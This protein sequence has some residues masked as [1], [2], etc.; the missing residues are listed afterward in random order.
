MLREEGLAVGDRQGVGIAAQGRVLDPGE[1]RIAG[2][3]SVARGAEVA[4][5]GG[6]GGLILS[7]ASR[8]LL[9]SLLDDPWEQHNATIPFDGRVFAF[10]LLVTFA[11][12]TLFGLLPAWLA[13]RK[14]VSSQLKES[15]HQATRRRKSWSGKAVVALQIALSTVLVI[16]AGIFLHTVLSLNSIDLGFDP[17][18]ILMFDISPPG[19]KYTDNKAVQLHQQLE[20]QIAAL[21]GVE[22]VSPAWIP[23]AGGGMTNSGFLTEDKSTNS[24]DN[25]P[26]FDNVVGNDYFRTMRIPIVAGRAF[27]AS[28]TPSSLKVAVINQALA[29][30]RFPN[31][32]PIGKRFK[33]GDGPKGDEAGPDWYQIVGICADTRYAQVK[34][35]PPPVFYLPYVQQKDSSD[36]TY[37]IRTH[38][39]AATLVP[40]QQAQ[41]APASQPQMHMNP[42]DFY[43]LRRYSLLSGPQLPLIEKYFAEALIPALTRLNLG[44]VGTF[45]L[46]VGPETP[47]Y[48]LLVPVRTTGQG[49]FLDQD[50]ATDAEFQKAAE[51]FWSA[52]ASA[53]ASLRTDSQLLVSFEGWPRITPP[54]KT[55]GRIFQLRT[56]ESPS[57]HDHEVKVK[58]FHAGE[59][60]IFKAAGFRPVFFGDTLIGP[61][62]PNLTYMLAFDSTAQLEAQWNAFR[63]DPAWKKL[64][65]DPKYAYESIVDNITNLYLSP[66]A[67]SQ[68]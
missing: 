46:D 55:P 26:E 33:T 53:P 11:T 49:A 42:R 2:E 40:A 22:S 47:T 25:P 10:T 21:P 67:S 45:K 54:A 43:L 48:Y 7:F 23:L 12:A 19:K 57:L 65:T 9:P 34:D 35:D 59:F 44:P 4:A 50:L 64:S 36:M 16:G 13:S 18:H 61:R 39:S 20:Q 56:Y 41:Q 5:L 1:Q 32:N 51:P 31:V 63:N 58:M 3:R 28:D 68:I 66:L 60:D 24:K 8:N 62:Q 17:N 15:S 30:K 38:A 29:H 6:F 37:Q 27:N 14:D 52:P